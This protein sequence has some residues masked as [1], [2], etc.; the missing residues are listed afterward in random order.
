MLNMSVGVEIY[1]IHCLLYCEERS[2]IIICLF[3][4]A[5]PIKPHRDTH[6]EEQTATYEK[7]LQKR[8]HYEAN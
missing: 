3:Q 5:R 7:P 1:D 6:K 8:K 4:A 2:F